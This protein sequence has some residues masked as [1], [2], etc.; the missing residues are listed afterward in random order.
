[1]TSKK[2]KELLAQYMQA[3]LKGQDNVAESLENQLNEA[4]WFIVTGQDGLTVEKRKESGGFM[5]TF[6]NPFSNSPRESDIQPYSST[7]GEKSKSNLWLIIG[8]SAGAIGLIVLM[9]YLIKR[10][11]KNGKV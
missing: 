2:A 7:K 6:S 4:G 8:I 3:E 1:M 10:F 9:V 5:D 11:R